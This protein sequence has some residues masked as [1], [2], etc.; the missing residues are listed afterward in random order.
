MLQ[1]KHSVG[2]VVAS[3]VCVFCAPAVR[4]TSYVAVTWGDDRVHFLNDSLDDTGSFATEIGL[5]NGVATEGDRK[6]VV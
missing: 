5:P 1:S 6:S 3:A 4:A 2:V